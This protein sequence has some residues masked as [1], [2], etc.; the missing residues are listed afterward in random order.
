[1]LS[2]TRPFLES[3]VAN[4]LGSYRNIQ[5]RE[6]TRVIGLAGNPSNGISGV[7]VSPTNEGQQRKEIVADLIVDATGRGSAT[8]TWLKELGFERP[9]VEEI[10]ARVTYATTAFRRSDRW[11]NCRALAIGGAPTRRGGFMLPVEQNRWLV[12]LAGYFEDQ[13]PQDHSEFF[14]FA[15]SLPV[16]GTCTP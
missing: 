5:L 1:M 10:P 14:V 13:M 7:Y 11:P 15:R 8:P 16:P 3:A 2:M 4:R 9:A 12:S 6:A